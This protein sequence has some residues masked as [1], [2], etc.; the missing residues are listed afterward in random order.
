M[1]AWCTVCTLCTAC[2][3]SPSVMASTPSSPRSPNECSCACFCPAPVS[4]P[5]SAPTLRDFLS[6]FPTK[7]PLPTGAEPR[8][9]LCRSLRET[10]HHASNGDVTATLA[11]LLDHVADCSIA[12]EHNTK[13]KEASFLFL[14]DSQRVNSNQALSFDSRYYEYHLVLF[15]SQDDNVSIQDYLRVVDNMAELDGKVKRK[16]VDSIWQIFYSPLAILVSCRDWKYL[17]KLKRLFINRNIPNVEILNTIDYFNQWVVYDVLRC[18]QDYSEE[19]VNALSLQKVLA[20]AYESNLQLS[21]VELSVENNLNNAKA[22]AYPFLYRLNLL[23]KDPSPFPF[24]PWLFPDYQSCDCST[25]NRKRACKR[26][27]DNSVGSIIGHYNSRLSTINSN[28]NN[29]N[30]S[31]FHGSRLQYLLNF[32][33]HNNLFVQFINNVFA[34]QSIPRSLLFV[35]FIDTYLILPPATALLIFDQFLKDP[36]A[37][38]LVVANNFIQRSLHYFL[39]NSDRTTPPLPPILNH[40][41]K[42]LSSTQEISP[43]LSPSLLHHLP[44]FF[45]NVLPIR[46]KLHSH[47][48]FEDHSFIKIYQY[49]P[50]LVLILQS[51]IST[52][53]PSQLQLQLQLSIKRE[54]S[55][56]QAF[57]NYLTPIKSIARY[58]QFDFSRC[59]VT[60][61]HPFNIITSLILQK[62]AADVTDLT[63]PDL[64][65]I[66][67][68]CLISIVLILQIQS[69]QWIRNGDSL[70][71]QSLMYSQDIHMK[72][73]LIFNDY[74][75][76]RQTITYSNLDQFWQNYLSKLKNDPTHSLLILLQLFTSPIPHNDE[77]L[78]QH[79]IINCLNWKKLSYS[80]L[81]LCLPKN[82]SSLP[83]FTTILSQTTITKNSLYQLKKKYLTYINPY[84]IGLTFSQ[85]TD[86]LSIIQDPLQLAIFNCKQD[87]PKVFRLSSS[88]AFHRYLLDRIE[89]AIRDD[90]LRINC[91][92]LIY[93][94]LL[95]NF[96]NFQS[97]FTPITISHLKSLLKFDSI[98][99]L[100]QNILRMTSNQ[101]LIIAPFHSLSFSSPS[102]S[103]SL[104]TRN[105][106]KIISHHKKL[107]SKFSKQQNLFLKYNPSLSIDSSPVKD[108]C[109]FC[110]DDL[111]S[112]SIYFTFTEN[113]IIS[114]TSTHSK[115]GIITNSCGHGAHIKCLSNHMQAILPF[116]FQSTKNI[117]LMWGIGILYCPVC[118]N[119][120]NSFLPVLCENNL[121]FKHSQLITTPQYS[122]QF[123]EFSFPFKLTLILISISHKKKLSSI[124]SIFNEL[125]KIFINTIVNLQIYLTAK[126]CTLTTIPNQKLITIKLLANLKTFIYR[127]YYFNPEIIQSLFNNFLNWNSFLQIIKND[128]TFNFIDIDRHLL[129]LSSI[130]YELK[131]SKIELHNLT[132]TDL[133]FKKLHHD[134]FNLSKEFIQNGATINL[135]MRNIPNENNEISLMFRIFNRYLSFFNYEPSTMAIDDLKL[136][137]YSIIQNSLKIFFKKL[138]LLIYSMYQLNELSLTELD[139]INFYLKFFHAS[140]PISLSQ[141]LDRFLKLELPIIESTLKSLSSSSMLTRNI[142][143]YNLSHSYIETFQNFNLIHL[144]HNYSDLIL[145]TNLNL[146]KFFTNFNSEILKFDIAICLFCN[147]ILLFKNLL[148]W[149]DFKLGECT[150]HSR[151]NCKVINTFG[152]FILPFANVIYISY[153]TRGSFIESP[154]KNK[155][156]TTDTNESLPLILN[157]AAWNYL[158]NDI[159]LNNMIP[160]LIFRKTDGN[161]DIG[162]WEIF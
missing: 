138:I 91:V 158:K 144:P 112:N 64:L 136:K 162:G 77:L 93:I 56:L 121:N 107:L 46:K 110:K 67:E 29:N 102:P 86:L 79:E 26:A 87:N 9:N 28:N 99:L 89:L 123:T 104:P 62:L 131:F 156:N 2:T 63:P 145:Q 42:L 117:P 11:V 73:F 159:L 149:H 132:I 21:S 72:K 45:S 129:F 85:S 23:G 61:L 59:S 20:N 133:L 127:Y 120:T 80:N 75:I 4:A 15:Q 114:H 84:Y 13:C 30:I 103:P 48:L 10:L 25:N 161:L 51:F 49:I 135:P 88:P 12:I 134:F 116:A 126:N 130:N 122:N 78:I 153:G 151:N 111:I 40:V 43:S 118:S 69:N 109:C 44:L 142:I 55:Q 66:S 50:S 95:N 65:L 154:Y 5:V 27:C 105:P 108:E 74:Y 60:L 32:I 47:I 92:N 3:S 6:V 90:S 68:P 100:L 140:H 157:E 94:C 97:F 14:Q 139:D 19:Q 141:I 83:K 57:R 81:L 150:N 98:Q 76:L 31:L 24:G 22:F 148:P 143:H 106:K 115:E 33:P 119:L 125:N 124:I 160:H 34:I 1:C 137:I 18:L 71:L 146:Q 52:L 8:Y 113:S 53:S 58:L 41:W 155:F 101:N 36:L 17:D 82:I 7:T 16:L 38:R 39:A 35:Q 128:S 147:K 152:M 70:K 96:K 37:T 54:L